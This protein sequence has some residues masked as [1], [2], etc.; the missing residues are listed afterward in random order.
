MPNDAN[1]YLYDVVSRWQL[2]RF[3]RHLH[4]LAGDLRCAAFPSGIPKEIA[5]GELLHNQP[6]PEQENELIFQ[7][8]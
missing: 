7:P 3:C 6:L 4:S 1:L 2:C 5:S 8:W